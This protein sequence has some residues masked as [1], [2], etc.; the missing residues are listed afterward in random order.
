MDAN[1]HAKTVTVFA[2]GLNIPTGIAVGYGGVWVMNSP[3][4]LFFR[5]SDG[6][7]ASPEIVARDLAVMLEEVDVEGWHEDCGR[8]PLSHMGRGTEEDPCFF[9]TA[10]AAGRV[11]RDRVS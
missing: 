1:G 9:M 7:A 6:Q 4:L 2:D 8:L 10:F 3:D 5:E 11:A